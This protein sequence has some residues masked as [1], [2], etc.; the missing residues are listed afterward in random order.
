MLRCLLGAAGPT[1]CRRS[2][3]DSRQ[4]GEYAGS[5]WLGRPQFEGEVEARGNAH[6][7]RWRDG[8][9]ATRRVDDSGVGDG[10]VVTKQSLDLGTGQW[11]GHRRRARRERYL[12]GDR[13]GAIRRECNGE[14]AR[15]RKWIV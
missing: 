11:K 4:R 10:D 15:S 14:V 12:S 9:G 5:S 13:R 1:G 7:L 3:T 8:D 2:A 6:H